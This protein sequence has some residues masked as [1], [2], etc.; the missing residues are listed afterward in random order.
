MKPFIL[1]G[2][3]PLI[4]AVR[5]SVWERYGESIKDGSSSIHFPKDG[6]Q[7]AD[8]GHD[9]AHLVTSQQFWQ[10]LHIYKGGTANLRAPGIFAAIADQVDAEFASTTFDR[11]VG[12]PARG[13]Q[14]DGRA[15]PNRSTRHLVNGDAAEANALPDFLH[16]Y[17]VA[18]V[19]VPS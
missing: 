4:H 16:A 17:L 15:R 6:I 5:A 19:T 8:N 7:A 11:E 9:I 12:L 10:D 3:S 13:A 18:R 14:G 2:R 1:S